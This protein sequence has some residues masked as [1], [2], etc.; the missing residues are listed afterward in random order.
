MTV[1][2][3]KEDVSSTSAS[4]KAKWPITE[5]SNSQCS[6]EGQK[7]SAKLQVENL[8]YCHARQKRLL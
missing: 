3:K 1:S 2:V 8:Y 5:R 7:F 6:E 4:H